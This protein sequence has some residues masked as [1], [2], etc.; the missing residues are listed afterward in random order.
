M[1]NDDIATSLYGG[2][3]PATA[4]ASEP[5]LEVSPEQRLYAPPAPPVERNDVP[6][7]IQALRAE[8][9]SLYAAAPLE[10][11]EGIDPIEAGR[12][13]MDLGASGEDSR[14][15]A[16]LEAQVLAADD[17]QFDAWRSESIELLR[18]GQI[19]ESDLRLAQRLVARD[20]RVATYLQET[21]LGDHPVVVRRFVELARGQAV[22]GRLKR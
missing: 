20:L 14:T 1:N 21:G 3:T 7:D 16:S 5:S 2:T 10:G 15:L 19:D 18:S 22:R 9:R 11:L 8:E 17:A 12:V 13:A 6:A 4:P